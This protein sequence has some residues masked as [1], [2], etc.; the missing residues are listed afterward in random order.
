MLRSRILLLLLLLPTTAAARK[1]E[2]IFGGQILIS[3]Q[4]FPTSAK[5]EQ[6]YVDAL[7]KQAKDRIAEDKEAKQWRVFFAAFFK[8]S[9]ND[10]EINVRVYDVTNGKRLVDTFEQYLGSPTTRAY[11]S[12]VKLA[13]SDGVTGYDPNSKIQ[14]IME[15]R[16]RVVAQATFYITG[17][18]KKA[19]PSNL[20]FTEPETK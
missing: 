8:Q 14:M 7:K 20:E 18:V 5:S 6:A 10:L 15:S 1:P 3:P 12:D 9:L 2:D 16:G 17:E 19:G 13:R 11:V 4:P